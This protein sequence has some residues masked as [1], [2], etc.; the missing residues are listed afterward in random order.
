MY[1]KSKVKKNIAVIL[2]SL[3]LYFCVRTG[4][5][6]S[7]TLCSRQTGIMG[8]ELLRAMEGANC[9]LTVQVVDNTIIQCYPVI[10]SVLYTT[11]RG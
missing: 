9:T 3:A 6:F 4:V 10:T 2:H 11:I 8:I 1:L 5:T 7:S